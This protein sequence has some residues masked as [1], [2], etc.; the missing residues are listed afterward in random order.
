MRF[1]KVILL[2]VLLNG[3]TKEEVTLYTAQIEN[4]TS[5]YLV[6]MPYFSG[7]VPPNK[8]ITINPG[9]TVEI[10]HGT[11]RGIVDNAGFFSD[12]LS[13][14]D[15]IIVVFDNQ[16]QITHYFEVPTLMNPKHYLYLSLRNLYNK[17][18]YF[19]TFSDISK[20][21][22]ESNYLYKFIEQD[23]IDSK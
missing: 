7:F 12:Y 8:I 23:Y 10:G 6:V 22:R 15:S 9:Q 20:N 11:N 13:G 19:Y 3:C 4:T 5:H 1:L 18:N 14:S 16:Y 2:I 17:D 21:R